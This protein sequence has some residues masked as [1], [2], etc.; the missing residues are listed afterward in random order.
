MSAV[1]AP[2]RRSPVAEAVLAYL[3]SHRWAPVG[4]A[5]LAEACAASPRAVKWAV[6]RLRDAGVG[7]RSSRDGYQLADLPRGAMVACPR[8]GR[9]LCR[10]HAGVLGRW[11]CR[12]C[13]W[14]DEPEPRA[15]APLVVRLAPRTC[16]YCG[17]EI[18]RTSAER[19]ARDAR[20]GLAYCSLACAVAASGRRRRKGEDA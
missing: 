1:A 16:G 8:C 10:P 12:A 20:H 19:A 17:G 15:W 14:A 18:G 7:I 6:A 5:E 4:V 3:W 11:V 2:W 9:A 13:G